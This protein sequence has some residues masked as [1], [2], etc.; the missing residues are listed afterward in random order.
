MEVDY[1]GSV[2]LTEIGS[3]FRFFYGFIMIFGKNYQ[4]DL[5][6]QI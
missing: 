4:K 2:E 5:P 3:I 1:L 6:S